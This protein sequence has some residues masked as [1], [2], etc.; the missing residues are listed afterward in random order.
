MA[1]PTQEPE[2]KEPEP[3]QEPAKKKIAP[4]PYET[5]Q[6]VNEKKKALQARLDAI[7]AEQK[8]AKDEALA[9]QNK[10]QEL[11]ESR[12]KELNEAKLT[13]TRL[14]VAAETKLPPALIGRLQGETEEEIKADAA[15]LMEILKQPQ[16]K[17]IPPI[18]NG[19]PAPVFDIKGKTA[20]EIRE[21]ASKL[22]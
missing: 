3:T 7:E 9:E 11:A 19:N 10:W 5:F 17:G 14:K 4:V 16:G 8:K 2:N 22:L 13:N 12:E 21:N 6:K 20:K 18:P 15:S 1:E